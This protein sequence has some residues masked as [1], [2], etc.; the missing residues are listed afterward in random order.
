MKNVWKGLVVGGLTGVAA[1]M[2]LDVAAKASA[3]ATAL[4]EQVRGHV[5]EAGRFIHGVGDRAGEWL[6]EDV[7]DHVKAVA[8]K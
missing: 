5:P 2:V 3:K 7:P 6:Q 8:E 1:G 4:G